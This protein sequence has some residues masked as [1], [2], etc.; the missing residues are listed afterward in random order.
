METLARDVKLVIGMVGLPA[1]GKTYISRKIARYLNWLGFKCGVFNI[2][3]YRRMICGTKECTADF[4]DPKNDEAV[5]ARNECANMALTDLIKFLKEGG[6]VAIYDGTNTSR[7]RRKMAKEVMKEKLESHSLMWIE[8]ICNDEKIIET[9][10]RMTKLSSPDYKDVDPEI[11]TMDFR[12]RIDQYKKKY[13]ELSK[14]GDGEDT[15]YI[16]LYDVGSQFIMNNITG[17]IES[18]VVSFLMNLHI[19]PRPIYF[20][21]HGESL[22]NIEDRV[23][24]DPDLSERGY[25]YADKL[26]GFFRTEL[27]KGNI[28]KNTKILTSTLKRAVITSNTLEIGAKPV[29]LKSLDELNAGVCDGMSYQEIAIK[30]PIEIKERKS[31]KLNYR[32]PRGESYLD[33]IQRIEPIIFEVER[34]KQPVIVIAHQAVI[35]CLYAYFSKHDIMEIPYTSIPLHTVIKLIPG[36][37][38]AHE[39]NFKIDVDTGAVEETNVVNYSLIEDYRSVKA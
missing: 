16:K 36:T 8:S 10:I 19:T 13:Q 27:E 12:Q 39:T 34:S 14:E 25:K 29:Y 33:V 3:E 35:R 18:K 5:K 38:Y 6:D 9:N 2:G 1:R 22:F 30:F 37:Y 17:Y 26:N 31:D 28:Q 23:G 7:E 32:Y 15:S 24:G 21:R 4:F 11:A 20:T